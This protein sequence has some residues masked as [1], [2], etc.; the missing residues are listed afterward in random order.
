[1]SPPKRTIT[2]LAALGCTRPLRSAVAVSFNVPCSRFHFEKII[3]ATLAIQFS[4]LVTLLL[5]HQSDIRTGTIAKSQLDIPREQPQPIL[6]NLFQGRIVDVHSIT[7]NPLTFKKLSAHL[8][9]SLKMF[10]PPVQ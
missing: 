2:S 3:A 5:S 10:N 6:C 8:K 7:H 1:M 9:R 4:S